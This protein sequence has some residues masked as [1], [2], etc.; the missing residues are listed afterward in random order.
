MAFCSKCGA[1]VPEGN[2]FCPNCGAQM[3]G[4]EPQYQDPQYQY[5]DPQYQQPQYQQPYRAPGGYR[6]NIQK[7]NPVTC[8]LLSIVTCGIYGLI[9]FFNIVNDL[10]TA[11]Q[12]PEDKTAVTIILLSIVTCGIY[13][14]I[15]LYNAGQKVDKIRQFNG[16][17]PSN[18]GMTY[19]LLSIFGLGVVVYYLI[20]QELNKVA[21]IEG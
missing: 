10:N 14:I 9:W 17:A 21:A 12:T 4:P 3:N 16:E 2:T 5:Q 6:A 18:S 13:G 19:L 15:W 11:A 1:N 8:I 7:R 20:Q